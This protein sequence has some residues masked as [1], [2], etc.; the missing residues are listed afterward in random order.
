MR[1]ALPSGDILVTHAGLTH[2]AWQALG[3]PA[4][5]AEVAVALN[6]DA[7]G[8]ARVTL[9]EGRM[10]TG[11]TDPAAGPLWA[12]AGAE[13]LMSWDQ[14]DRCPAPEPDPRTQ[15]SAGMVPGTVVS[16][17]RSDHQPR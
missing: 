15:H 5:A 7:R 9:R 11:T 4:T 8:T 3:G 1:A 16:G 10:T 2:G 13:L 14:H 6:A 12:E 17:R